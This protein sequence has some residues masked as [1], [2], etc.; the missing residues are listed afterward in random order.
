MLWLSVKRKKQGKEGQEVKAGKYLLFSI[1]QS[2]KT[3]AI[4]WHLT[5]KE[6]KE[7]EGGGKYSR[8]KEK[9]VW[10]TLD[11]LREKARRPV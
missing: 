9:L 11:G 5:P 1:E 7:Q 6:V 4:C 10:R 8:Q 2:E 3:L